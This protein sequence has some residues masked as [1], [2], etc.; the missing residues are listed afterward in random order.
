VKTNCLKKLTDLK[1]TFVSHVAG[2]TRW[3]LYCV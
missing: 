2:E 3:F 1:I